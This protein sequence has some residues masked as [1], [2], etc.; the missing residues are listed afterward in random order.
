M[1]SKMD[2]RWGYHNIRI[3]EGDKWKCVFTMHEGLYEPLVMLFEMC[4]SLLTFQHMLNNIFISVIEGCLVIF[5]DN[6]LV[7]TK[8]LM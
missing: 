6:L 5:M 1:F 3:R 2:V 4:N 8:K 7:F